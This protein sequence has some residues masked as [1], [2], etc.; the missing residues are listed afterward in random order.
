MSSN[1]GILC[2]ST[3]RIYGSGEQQKSISLL[4]KTGMKMC[5]I[6][7]KKQFTN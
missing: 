6:Q 3:P 5:Y 4:G 1:N 2:G 7:G